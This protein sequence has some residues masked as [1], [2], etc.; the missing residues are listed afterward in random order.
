MTMTHTCNLSSDTQQHY[1]IIY[2][3]HLAQIWF[4]CSLIIELIVHNV[5][6]YR[7]CP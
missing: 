3:I 4:S 2:T 5:G 7:R 1:T 6:N